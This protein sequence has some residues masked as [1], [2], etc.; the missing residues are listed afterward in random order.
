MKLLLDEN[1]SFR[2]ISLLAEDYPESQHVEMAGLGGAPD[3]MIWRHARDAGFVLVS[4]DDDFYHRSLVNGAPP[5]VVWL[6][7]GNAP[8][9][10]VAACLRR[11][12]SRLAAFAVSATDALLVL[13]LEDSAGA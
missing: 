11:N 2:L 1:L 10:A 4:K 7:I 5:K 9:A 6:Q 13:R 8:T 12:R 3:E